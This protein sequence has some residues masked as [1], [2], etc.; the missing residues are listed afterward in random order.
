MFS[1]CIL[2]LLGTYYIF[3]VILYNIVILYITYIYI[4]VGDFNLKD[5]RELICLE[6]SPHA[7]SIQVIISK[8]DLVA[9]GV[10]KVID[11]IQQFCVNVTFV[12]TRYLSPDCVFVVGTCDASLA[13]FRHDTSR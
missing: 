5:K 11:L 4:I 8:M 6:E 13:T 9:P 12:V 10:P 1:K 7:V 2:N 3:Y